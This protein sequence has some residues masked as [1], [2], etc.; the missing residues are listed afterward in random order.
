MRSPRM[1]KSTTLGLR[2][3]S[4]KQRTSSLLL[5]W[6]ACSNPTGSVHSRSIQAVRI[7]FVRKRLIADDDTVIVILDS[8][9]MTSVTPEMF[10]E[11]E[12]IAREATQGRGLLP[13]PCSI[14]ILIVLANIRHPY[15]SKCIDTK[16]ACSRSCHNALRGFGSRS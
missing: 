6:P 8:K 9:L 11:G 7:V 4:P 10:A 12:K 1:A 16:I 13:Y 2:T 5:T 14:S 3:R 15:A